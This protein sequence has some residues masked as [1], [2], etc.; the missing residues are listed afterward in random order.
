M[1]GLVQTSAEAT[2]SRALSLLIVSRDSYSP[3]TLDHVQVLRRAKPALV[4]VTS[5]FRYDYNHQHMCI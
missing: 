1:A 3:K 4:D 5:Y 2:R